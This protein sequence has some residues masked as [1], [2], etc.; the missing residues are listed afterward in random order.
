[1]V[2]LLSKFQVLWVIVIVIV[3]VWFDGKI[4][5]YYPHDAA[6][7]LLSF[8][9]AIYNSPLFVGYYDRQ[10]DRNA[11]RWTQIIHKK[12]P[13]FSARRSKKVKV[14]IP[15]ISVLLN[16]QFHDIHIHSLLEY[17]LSNLFSLCMKKKHTISM[18]ALIWSGT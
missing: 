17:L 6:H 8:L 18:L 3:I 10:N 16:D 2:V 1:M 12:S 11:R 5:P 14:F 13:S 9:I 15:I 7:S 4:R